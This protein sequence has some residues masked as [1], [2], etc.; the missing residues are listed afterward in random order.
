MLSPHE[1]T[2]LIL[3]NAAPDQI[4]PDRDE[5]RALVESHL[6]SLDTSGE[7]PPR[8]RITSHGKA[9][10]EAFDRYRAGGLAN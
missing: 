10:L 2:T 5:L 1:F 8:V 3:V 9:I 6:I 7:G 4:Q